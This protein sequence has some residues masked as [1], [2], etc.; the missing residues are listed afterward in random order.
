MKKVIKIILFVLITIILLLISNPHVI[1]RTIRNSTLN[2]KSL[3][4]LFDLGKEYLKS[5]MVINDFAEE[6]SNIALNY[7][8]EWK[9]YSVNNDWKGKGL[10]VC[11][12]CLP[13]IKEIDFNNIF[14]QT[15]PNTNKTQYFLY[16][17]YYDN[18]GNTKYV[19]VVG[20]RMDVQP[21]DFFVNKRE[22]MLKHR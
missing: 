10:N 2:N 15:I 1:D 21:I 18:R 9:S 17:A 12:T 13:S 8:N 7:Y 22:L 5:E 20:T 4:N 3:V 19:R 6:Q 11:E 14:W 16:N